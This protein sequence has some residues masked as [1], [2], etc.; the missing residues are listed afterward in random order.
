MTEKSWLNRQVDRL[1]EKLPWI[2]A[3]GVSSFLHGLVV[4]L[5]S[6]ALTLGLGRILSFW[7]YGVLA[8]AV[9][10][11]LWALGWEQF[12]LRREIGD[13]QRFKKVLH[14]E[15]WETK[16]KDCYRDFGYTIVPFIIAMGVALERIL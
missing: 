5:P 4:L 15:K 12:Y 14:G 3:D 8:S 10:G 11:A 6:L 16:K 13:Y 7:T 9:L 2:Y 1:A